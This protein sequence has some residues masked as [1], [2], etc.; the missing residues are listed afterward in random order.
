MELKIPFTGK[1]KAITVFYI[2][3]T[4][5]KFLRFVGVENGFLK[6]QKDNDTYA[7]IN[8][9]QVKKIEEDFEEKKE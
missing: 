1:K 5:E 7:Y 9:S 2:D 3:K 6:L 8:P 4:E